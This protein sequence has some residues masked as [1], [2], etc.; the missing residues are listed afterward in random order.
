[1]RHP[2]VQNNYAHGA[3]T[4]DTK[5]SMQLSYV[6][7][8]WERGRP[9]TGKMTCSTGAYEGTF[10]ADGQ[11]APFPFL[12]AEGVFRCSNGFVPWIELSGS[13]DLVASRF[14]GT[15]KYRDESN[16]TGSAN[17]TYNTGNL[18]TVT[19]N[20]TGE[21]KSLT[22]V[23]EGTFENDFFR[24]KCTYS[25]NDVYDGDMQNGLKHGKGSL[26]NHKGFVE[27]SGD[28]RNDAKV[29]GFDGGCCIIM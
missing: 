13:F 23:M 25:N 17:I 19:K 3:G 14:Q 26:L 12:P 2:G 15:V 10:K 4:L 22:Q 28:W 6:D 8:T 7:C 11:V 29:D 16:Y 5:N 20:G 21:Y 24:G 18:F 9:T 1:M 27:H